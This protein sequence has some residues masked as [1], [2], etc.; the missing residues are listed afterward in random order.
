MRQSTHVFKRKFASFWWGD[1]GM[2][3]FL[4]LLFAALFLAP[5]FESVLL[6]SLSA[7]FFSLLLIS[8]VAYI[9]PRPLWRRVTGTIAFTAIALRWLQEFR[10]NPGLWSSPPVCSPCPAWLS[11]SW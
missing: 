4:L 10:A 8:G 1:Q 7:I 3:A 5:F 6:R 2:L 9:S 11:C